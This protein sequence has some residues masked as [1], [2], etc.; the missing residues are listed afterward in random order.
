[1]LL[2]IGSSYVQSVLVLVNCVNGGDLTLTLASGHS[3]GVDL[4][5]LVIIFTAESIWMCTLLAWSLCSY[6]YEQ[7][8]ATEKV[9]LRHILLSNSPIGFHTVVQNN[10]TE[11][12]QTRGDG[13]DLGRRN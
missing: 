10:C 6:I 11:L 2:R 12:R 9:G 7:Y 3:V 5:G 13:R 8:S 4:T 1:M